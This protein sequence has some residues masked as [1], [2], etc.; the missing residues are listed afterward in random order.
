MVDASSKEIPRFWHEDRTQREEDIQ[1]RRRQRAIFV[2][3]ALFA[4]LIGAI[5]AMLT[6]IHVVGRPRLSAL[7]V[8]TPQARSIPPTA[9]GSGDLESLIGSGLFAHSRQAIPPSQDRAVFNGELAQLKDMSRGDPVVV[10]VRALACLAAGQGPVEAGA[11]RGQLM[12]LPADA[13]P[14]DP[15]AWLPFKNI[16]ESLAQCRVHHKLLIVDVMQGVADPRLALLSGD[17]ATWIGEELKAVPDER[18]LVLSSCSPGQTTHVS[19]ILGRSIFNFFL[20]DGLRGWA[21]GAGRNGSSDGIVTVAELADYLAVQVDDWARR[22]RN[23]RQ[24][25]FVSGSIRTLDFPLVALPSGRRRQHLAISED[26]DYPAWLLGGW[27]LRDQWLADGSSSVAPWALRRMEALLVRAEEAWRNRASAEVI[28]KD[29]DVQLGDLKRHW[30]EVR[31]RAHPRPRTLG[32]E[33]MLGFKPDLAL[34]EELR[35]LLEALNEEPPAAKEKEAEAAKTKNEKIEAFLKSPKAV[36]EQNLAWAVFLTATLDPAPTPEKIVLLDGILA[37]R[38][39]DPRYLETLALRRAAEQAQQWSAL[40]Q[41]RSSSMLRAWRPQAI[42]G[43]LEVARLAGLAENRPVPLDWV[44]PLLEDAAQSR[45]EAEIMLWQPGY[46]TPESTQASLDLASALYERVRAIQEPVENAWNLV[47]ESMLLLPSFSALLKKSPEMESTWRT[48]VQETRNLYRLLGADPKVT[49]DSSVPGPEVKAVESSSS[50]LK[51]HLRELRT[52]ATDLRMQLERH[53]KEPEADGSVCVG[54]DALLETAFP[55][56]QER[57]LLWKAGRDLARRLLEESFA[58]AW[59]PKEVDSTVTEEDDGEEANTEGAIEDARRTARVSIDLLQLGGL[60]AREPEIALERAAAPDAV[61]S[62]PLDLARLLYTAWAK[63][64]PRALEAKLKDDSDLIGADRLSRIVP[65]LDQF[66][67]LADPTTNPTRRFN[68]RRLAQLWAWLADEYAYESRD[69]GASP[70]LAEAAQGCRDLATPPARPLI[71]FAAGLEPTKLGDDQASAKLELNYR[72]VSPLSVKPVIEPFAVSPWLK[73][74]SLRAPGPQ[75]GESRVA[76]LLVELYPPGEQSRSQP[77]QGFLVRARVGERAFHTRVNLDLESSAEKPF[78]VLTSSPQKPTDNLHALRVRPCKELQPYYLF[79]TNPGQRAR[80]VKIVAKAGAVQLPGGTAEIVVNGASTVPVIFAEKSPAPAPGQAATP[81]QAPTPSPSST[82]PLV[83]FEGPLSVSLFDADSGK[84]LAESRFDVGL[85]SPGEYVRLTGA[86]FEPPSAANKGTN[87]LVAT[88]RA[89]GLYPGPAIKAELVLP[90]S[91]IPGL[92]GTFE[93]TLRAELDPKVGEATLMAQNIPL[94]DRENEHGISYVNIDE[95]KR[96][97]VLDTTFA[98]HGDAT[99]P[100]IDLRPDVRVQ[101]ESPARSG[102]KYVVLV[103]VD[104]APPDAVLLL[105]LGRLELSGFV[106]DRVLPPRGPREEHLRVGLAQ[107]SLAFEAALADWSIPFDTEGLSGSLAL[108]AVLAGRDGRPIKSVIH[109]VVLDDTGPRNVR[110]V[111]LPEQGRRGSQLLVS[112]SGKPSESGTKEVNFFWGKPLPD[113]KLPPNVELIKA[114]PVDPAGATWNARLT[115]PEKK[116]QAPLSVQFLSATGVSSFDSRAIELVDIDPNVFG[117]LRIKVVEG[118][119]L[120][121]GL[122]VAVR[123]AKGAVK[124]QGKTGPDGIYTTGKLE[125]GQYQVYAFKQAT[126]SEGRSTVAVEPGR[127]KA[128]TLDL[129][130][131]IRL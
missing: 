4:A 79:L 17:V 43:G 80:K 55:G 121:S 10:Y 109:H 18:R 90:P 15:V 51:E 35:S 48:A 111:D 89:I 120:Q 40:G 125:K 84:L 98:R 99:T 34:V 19:E 63:E 36:S 83:E 41:E 76:A 94:D 119:R 105:S 69:L 66:D 78:I 56:A 38:H 130:Y 29:L 46:S 131:R 59:Q 50:S 86:R 101:A 12:V 128:V 100:R 24:R 49:R 106:P 60:E 91:R 74:S 115:L 42:H 27:R 58:T 103:E 23:S 32:L 30:G 11:P 126:P 52:F 64:L 87:R 65:P 73:V 57:A 28:E 96:A 22:N 1:A 13:D 116:G 95:Y 75:L 93:G 53:S 20:E 117:Q 47:D 16:L 71:R 82:P 114:T 61:L 70:L 108:R 6:W 81:G 110:I 45:H 3:L 112:A 67:K 127:T 107:G 5:V 7:W 33:S 118:D 104:H 85:A 124:Q 39:R 2:R 123:D 62:Y 31:K 54:I 21:D 102:S 97:F 122:E 72:V 129:F 9:M 88:L 8:V 92:T 44:R 14:N 77:P 37:K 68:D 113:G 25:P 26:R